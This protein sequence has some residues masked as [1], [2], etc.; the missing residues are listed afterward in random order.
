MIALTLSPEIEGRLDALATKT[1]RS[2]AS[3][4]EEAIVEYMGDL[5]D[6]YLAEQ[7]LIDI[8]E[9]RSSAKPLSEVMKQYGLGN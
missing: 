8:R 1:G 6:V 4:L 7:E 2:K 5:E 9:G 3:F